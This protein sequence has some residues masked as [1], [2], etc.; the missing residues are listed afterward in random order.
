MNI[1]Y[2]VNDLESA[3]QFYSS[4]LG[5]QVVRKVA[6][7][8]ALMKLG[9]I[10][11]WLSGPGSPS[12]AQLPDG[13]RPQPGGWNRAMLGTSDLEAT[14][15]L[16]RNKAVK[17]RG[18]RFESPAGKHILVEDP[19]GNLIEIVEFRRQQQVTH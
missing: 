14:I 3:A 7:S 16:L 18:E 2:L 12:T 8:F 6:P 13:T 1:R 10:Q 17:F 5:F 11:L 9:N 4:K 19:S 15:N